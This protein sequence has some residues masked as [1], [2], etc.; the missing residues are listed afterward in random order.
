MVTAC[1]HGRRKS[2]LWVSRCN[3]R[4]HQRLT[5]LPLPA[6]HVPPARRLQ[7]ANYA[8]YRPGYPDSIYRRIY[9]FTAEASLPDPPCTDLVLDVGSGPGKAA[10]ALAQ[11]GC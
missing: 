9:E 11:V 1:M 6:W 3:I 8:A 2:L 10:V 4:H 5:F 7:A